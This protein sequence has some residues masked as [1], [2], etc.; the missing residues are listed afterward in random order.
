MNYKVLADK[1]IEDGIERLTGEFDTYKGKTTEIETEEHLSEEQ[2]N[3]LCE[4]IKKDD[5]VEMAMIESVKEST[6][7]IMFCR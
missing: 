2:L 3:L 1:Y 7:T 6:L 4:E 5:R